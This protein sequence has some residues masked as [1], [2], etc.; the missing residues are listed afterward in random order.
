MDRSV[1]ASNTVGECIQRDTA[2]RNIPKPCSFRQILFE[3]YK[4]N[5]TFSFSLRFFLFYLRNFTENDMFPHWITKKCVEIALAIVNAIGFWTAE[6]RLAKI[7][8]FDFK[9][10][11]WQPPKNDVTSVKIT[12][13]NPEWMHLGYHVDETSGI[14]DRKTSRPVSESK[15]KSLN[16]YR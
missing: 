12:M 5:I 8:H 14:V 7:N 13:I 1:R 15:R 2:S 11:F 6:S 4:S 3:P 10:T 16:P 9:R